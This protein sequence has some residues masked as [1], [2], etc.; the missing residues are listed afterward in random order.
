MSK[1]SLP[2]SL[3]YD[4]SKLKGLIRHFDVHLDREKAEGEAWV[5]DAALMQ[6]VHYGT[7]IL[8]PGGADTALFLLSKTFVAVEAV[9]AIAGVQPDDDSGALEDDLDSTVPQLV[10]GFVADVQN[11]RS[12]KSKAG[13]AT[14][15]LYARAALQ[16]IASSKYGIDLIGHIR[17]IAGRIQ[18][19]N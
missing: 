18:R 3:S 9:G 11:V 12:A 1:A 13:V 19:D 2:S 17:E 15:L 10:R 16:R 6:V 8:I 14:S 4:R 7:S 5:G